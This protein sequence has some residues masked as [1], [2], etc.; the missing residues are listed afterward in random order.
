MDAGQSSEAV[1]G[2]LQRLTQVAGA[3]AQQMDDIAGKV[4]AVHGRYDDIE[5]DNT[6]EAKRIERAS[7]LGDGSGGQLPAGLSQHWQGWWTGYGQA[8]DY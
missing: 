2:A 4:D 1:A 6:G 5:N 3:V 8:G 7:K